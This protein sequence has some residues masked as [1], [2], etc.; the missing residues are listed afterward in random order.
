MLQELNLFSN[1]LTD[2]N[3]SFLKVVQLITCV[4]NLQF[5]FIFFKLIT[6]FAISCSKDGIAGAP[7]A[8]GTNGTNGTNGINGNANVVG[9][10]TFTTS[11]TQTGT[12]TIGMIVTGNNAA[13]TGVP[14]STYVLNITGTTPNFTITLSNN[15]TTGYV[16]GTVYFIAAG[17]QGVYTTSSATTL[18]ATA[19]TMYPPQ[20]GKF[21][22]AA[23]IFATA[24]TSYP[25]GT[26][27]IVVTAAPTVGQ[28]NFVK[29]V[30]GGGPAVPISGQ[31]TYV[32]TFVNGANTAFTTQLHIGAEIAIAGQYLTVVNIISDTQLIVSQNAGAFPVQFLTPIYRT[33]PLYTYAISTSTTTIN[34]ATPIKTNLYSNGSNPPSVYFP[35]TGADFIEYV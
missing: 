11:G 12:I 22:Q 30:G 4:G 14:P 21:T 5:F 10:N 23:T 28:Y 31:V 17:G 25:I 1:L 8:T 7:G 33:V 29:I 13:I 34:L 20:I 19:I 35:S 15:L 18:S 16:T 6:L 24:G 3:N 32:S 26:Q 2:R 9:T 27:S